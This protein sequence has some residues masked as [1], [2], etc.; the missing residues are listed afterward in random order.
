MPGR[1]SDKDVFESTKHVAIHDPARRALCCAFPFV[2]GRVFYPAGSL[3]RSQWRLAAL[4]S[5]EVESAKSH[6]STNLAHI[7]SFVHFRR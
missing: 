3:G 1:A 7:F 2:S 6:E 5:S 4:V